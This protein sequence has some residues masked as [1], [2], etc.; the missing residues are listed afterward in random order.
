MVEAAGVASPTLTQ[1]QQLTE[2]KGFAIR[3]ILLKC[4]KWQV[5]STK[6]AQ[7]ASKPRLGPKL[8]LR[9]KRAQTGVE[10]ELRHHRQD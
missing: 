3:Q 4:H 6:K 7:K 1:F 9:A 8:R 2:H 5:G 10:M